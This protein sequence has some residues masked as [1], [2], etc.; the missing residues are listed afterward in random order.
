MDPWGTRVT[1]GDDESERSILPAHNQ[2]KKTSEVTI[3]YAAR[4]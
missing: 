2:I 4:E 1:I 3:S